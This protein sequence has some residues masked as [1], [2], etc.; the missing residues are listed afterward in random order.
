MTVVAEA[1]VAKVEVMAFGAFTVG[2]AADD[3]ATFLELDLAQNA[4][5]PKTF[6]ER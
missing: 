4:S 1:G 2:A 3:G 6:L 5:F